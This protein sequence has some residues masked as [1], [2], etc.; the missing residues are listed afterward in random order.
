MKR[1][2]SNHI[3]SDLF[4]I[5]F[6]TNICCCK[7]LT[8][9]NAKFWKSDSIGTSGFRKIIAPIII[10]D[11]NL[12]KVKWSEVESFFGSPKS[13]NNEYEDGKAV[14][15]MRYS[16]FLDVE[17]EERPIDSF[18]TQFFEIIIDKKDSTVLKTMLRYQD[19]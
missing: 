7:Y 10:Q 1:N 8:K 19:G 3:S 14:I 18:R 12:I 16:T 2:D 17:Y 15:R 5:R 11:C 13:S 9:I 4:I 6:D